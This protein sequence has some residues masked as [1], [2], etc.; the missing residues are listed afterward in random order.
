M[1]ISDERA[2]WLAGLK[3]GDAVLAHD[4]HSPPRARAVVFVDSTRVFYGD[5]EY[6]DWVW[7]EH[8][9]AL[10]DSPG[11]RWIEPPAPSPDPDSRIGGVE[12]S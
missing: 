12:A 8:G 11:H 5:G 9:H 3:S 2:A 7:R 1:M 10:L 6:P 4:R